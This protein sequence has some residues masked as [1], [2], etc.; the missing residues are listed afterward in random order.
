MVDKHPDMLAADANGHLRKFGS[1]RHYCFSHEGYKAEC[2]KIVTLL[3]ER[4]G[5]KVDAWQTDNEYGCHDTTL[6]YSDA[7]RDAFRQWLARRYNGVEALN[8]AWGNVFWSMDYDSF[9]QID[10]PNLTVTEPNPSH[11]LAFRRF[12]SDQVVRWNRAMVSALRP[13]TDAPLIHNFMGKVTEFDHWDMGRDLDIASWDS[14]PIGFLS[15]RITAPPAH[16]AQFLRQGDPDFQAFHH[17]LYRSVGRGRMWVMEQQPG[18]VNWAPWN[19]APAPGM[20]RLWGL[21]AVAHG[22]EV[23]SFFRWRQFPHA[24]EQYHAG[25]LYPDRTDAP[26]LGEVRT[27]AADLR[28]IGAVTQVQ[29]DVALIF[30][31][32]SDWASDVLPQGAD[33]SYFDLVFSAYRALRRAGLNVDLHPPTARDFA[34]YAA[35]LAPGLLEIPE[36]LQEALSDVPTLFGP[37]AGLATG[38]LS[39]RLPPGPGLTKTTVVVRDSESLPPGATLA[40]LGGAVQKWSDRATG[41]TPA[42]L[43]RSDGA[44]LV[45]GGDRQFYLTGWPNDPLWD[46]LVTWLADQAGLLLTRPHASLRRRKTADRVFTFNYGEAAVGSLPPCDAAWT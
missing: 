36:R 29:G 14:Y 31:Y 30:D 13:L 43:T 33:F 41:P 16:K 45:L 1:R 25:L 44:P 39:Q 40:A 42:L 6:S 7:A 35:V 32:A 26:G 22:A 24:Q 19:P 37:R 23:V 38:E 10:L 12:A 28:A 20:V 8:A 11:A 5:T 17:D 4:Y 27:L 18:P 21:E 34:G 3:A 9:D 46:D 15:D 2:A